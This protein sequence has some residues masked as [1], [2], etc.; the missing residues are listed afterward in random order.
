MKTISMDRT[1]KILTERLNAEEIKYLFKLSRWKD[2]H[3]KK[4]LV[5]TLARF[6]IAGFLTFFQ[7][8]GLFGERPY[9]NIADFSFIRLSGSEDLNGKVIILP[10]KWKID[11]YKIHHIWINNQ[12]LIEKHREMQGEVIF[13]QEI[14]LKIEDS[15]GD[16]WLRPDALILKWDKTCFI[17]SD[18]G[19]ERKGVLQEKGDLYKRYII[20]EMDKWNIEFNNICLTFFSTS[21]KRID[22]IRKAWVFHAFE[23]L[24]LIEYSLNK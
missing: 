17:E 22:R 16:I 13:D 8:V 20:Q 2:I 18:L 1:P 7:Y 23:L 10:K 9:L 24:D 19:S 15:F 12:N 6:K 4:K 21:Q 3:A 11:M 5:K 14:S